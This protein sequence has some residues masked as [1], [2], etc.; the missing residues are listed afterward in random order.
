MPGDE[1]LWNPASISECGTTYLRLT[2][3][4]NIAKALEMAAGNPCKIFVHAPQR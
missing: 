1:L 3:G 4:G 2:G